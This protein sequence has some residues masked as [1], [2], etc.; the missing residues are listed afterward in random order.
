M[1]KSV[2]IP[3]EALSPRLDPPLMKHHRIDLREKDLSRRH[4]S[5]AFPDIRQHDPKYTHSASVFYPRLAYTKSV[6]SGLKDIPEAIIAIEKS[7][8]MEK[9]K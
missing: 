7:K 6:K 1:S 3:P 5:E 2:F 8:L 4:L 9:K